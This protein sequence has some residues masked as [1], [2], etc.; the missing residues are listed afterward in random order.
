MNANKLKLNP[1]KVEDLLTG[2]GLVWGSVY[3]STLDGVALI[4]KA[5]VCS[6]WEPF[7]KS[8]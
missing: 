4:P 1:E 2:S 7:S 6:L 8:D 3:T 5:F